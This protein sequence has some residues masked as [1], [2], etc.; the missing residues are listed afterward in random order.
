V[1]TISILPLTLKIE[2]D[3]Q[4]RNEGCR[5]P[6][7]PWDLVTPRSLHMS[8]RGLRKRRICEGSFANTTLFYIRYLGIGG[9]EDHG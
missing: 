1:P 7:K 6:G 3:A 8:L 9:F 5:G 4:V 2:A